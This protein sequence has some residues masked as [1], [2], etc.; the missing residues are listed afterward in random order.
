M[1]AATSDGSASSSVVPSSSGAT[2]TPRSSTV[3][4]AQ[5]NDNEAEAAAAEAAALRAEMAALQERLA[6]AEAKERSCRAKAAVEGA[7]AGPTPP[8]ADADAPTMLVT[9]VEGYE[10][11]PPD[12]LQRMQVLNED[13]ELVDKPP[14]DE[15]EQKRPMAEHD[16]HLAGLAK[17]ALAHRRKG[18]YKAAASSRLEALSYARNV[19]RA[20]AQGLAH[21]SVTPE[22]ARDRLSS[23]VVNYVGEAVG[24]Y[25]DR[26]RRA[27]K[28]GKT[29]D[30]REACQYFAAFRETIKKLGKETRDLP[31]AVCEAWSRFA[32]QELAYALY[33]LGRGE[34]A[35]HAG[36]KRRPGC[37]GPVD[38][39]ATLKAA[40]DLDPGLAGPHRSAALGDL[41]AALDGRGAPRAAVLAARDGQVA[42]MAAPEEVEPAGVFDRARVEALVAES[43]E[44]LR[45]KDAGGATALLWPAVQ[46]AAREASAPLRFQLALALAL[47]GQHEPAEALL[48]QVLELE[49]T[50]AD[51]E[52]CLAN[53]LQA[54][55]R[56][57]EAADALDRAAELKPELRSWCE[58]EA[59]G[60]RAGKGG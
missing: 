18:R 57:A 4:S 33:T 10:E 44:L 20:R 41:A 45:A 16:A 54:L 3:A 5:T 56:A 26:G 7:D 31:G 50:F 25:N 15:A 52:L 59:E 23:A 32:S 21:E 22:A 42:A 38:A 27:L 6:R 46:A 36:A 47:E 11:G 28:R 13:G 24:E 1:D 12:E 53:C 43:R 40:L 35:G 19:H 9:E 2:P 34:L 49:P 48:R 37:E 8:G 60:L 29:G 17:E 30:Y 51:A 39:C 58:R 14:L 55:G